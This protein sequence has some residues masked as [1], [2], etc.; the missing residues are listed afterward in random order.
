MR[1]NQFIAS[2]SKLSRRAADQAITNGRVTI[3][4]VQA[5]LGQSVSTSDT[6]T[7]DGHLLKQSVTHQ[8]I[9]LNKPVGYICSRRGQ[10]S[11]TIFDLLPAELRHLQPVGRLD[12]DSSGLLLLTTDGDLTHK[13]THP[14]FEKPKVYEVTLDVELLPKDFE[15]ITKHGVKLDD[16]RSSFQL[17]YLDDGNFKWR[18]T[19]SEGRNRQIRRTFAALGYRV[20]KLHRI[21][22]GPY[23]LGQ[24]SSGKHQIIVV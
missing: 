9:M 5:K 1:I 10:G 3:N 19:M 21:Q 11:Q 16:G 2:A 17:D 4:G 14:S 12:K 23:K 18:V 7:L 13:L 15:T 22:F 8:T 20:E 6:V 24:L